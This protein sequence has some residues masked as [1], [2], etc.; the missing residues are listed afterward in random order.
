MVLVVLRESVPGLTVIWLASIIA[1]IESIV[2][3]ATV[4]ISKEI[5]RKNISDGSEDSINHNHQAYILNKRNNASLTL[6]LPN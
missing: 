1:L 5:V 6:L 3:K 2:L 4:N